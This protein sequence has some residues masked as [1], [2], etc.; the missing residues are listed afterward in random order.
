MTNNEK[1]SKIMAPGLETI[2]GHLGDHLGMIWGSILDNFGDPWIHG[3]LPKPWIWD[4]LETILETI[5]ETIWEP[6]A[7]SLE[8]NLA[9][10]SRGGEA[11]FRF[12][13]SDFS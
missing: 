5:W 13:C 7:C 11:T 4:H 6:G 10:R 12:Y 9:R 3:P 1:Y 2:W 8:F